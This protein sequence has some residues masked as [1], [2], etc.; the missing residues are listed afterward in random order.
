MAVDVK[1]ERAQVGV[2]FGHDM[3]NGLQDLRSVDIRAAAQRVRGQSNRLVG[4]KAPEI[5]RRGGGYA[6]GYERRHVGVTLQ[7]RRDLGMGVR[8]K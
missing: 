3:L 1:T 8:D 6:A 7:L 4:T 5:G 2:K